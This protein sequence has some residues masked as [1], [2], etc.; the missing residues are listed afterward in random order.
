M[1]QRGGKVSAL[2]GRDFVCAVLPQLETHFSRLDATP[3]TTLDFLRD[4]KSE[5]WHTDSFTWAVS[6][7]AA[8]EQRRTERLDRVQQRLADITQAC[9]EPG[10]TELSDASPYDGGDNDDD[11]NSDTD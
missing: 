10:I 8:L 3:D 4:F 1:T 6:V 11:D 5:T 2:L 7:D 9:M